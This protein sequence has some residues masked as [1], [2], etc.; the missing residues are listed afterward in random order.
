MLRRRV[1]IALV[2]L[3]WGLL[4]LVAVPATIRS[5][6]RRES[7]E[8]LN[9]AISG[10]EVHLV[11]HY[12][13][14]WY[15]A[16]ALLSALMFVAIVAARYGPSFVGRCRERFHKRGATAVPEFESRPLLAA[17][18]VAALSFGMLEAAVSYLRSNLLFEPGGEDTPAEALWM[19][20][21]D[22]VALAVLVVLLLLLLQRASGGRLRA[23]RLALPIV[24]ALG[25]AG[26]MLAFKVLLHPVAMALLSIGAGSAGSRLASLFTPEIRQHADRWLVRGAGVFLLLPLVP[27]TFRVIGS[28]MRVDGAAPARADGPNVI[29]LIW[30]TV[31]AANLSLHGYS[32]PTSPVLD[33]VATHGVAFDWAFATAPWSLPSHAGMMTGRLPHE[34]STGFRLPMDARYPTIGEVMQRAGYATAGFT[35]NLV[36][37]SAKFGIGRGLQHYDDQPPVSAVLVAARGQ[38]T[39]RLM[40]RVREAQG[41]Q[42]RMFRRRADHVNASFF[43]WIDGLPDRPF[44]AVLNH[45]DAHEPYAPPPPFNRT[46]SAPGERYWI[47]DATAPVPDSATLIQLRNAY[48][49]GIRYLDA[50]LEALLAGLRARGKLDRTILII[51]SDHGEEF[52]EHGNAVYGHMKSLYNGVLHVPM[53][54]VAPGLLP[55]GTRSDTPV[56]IRD[57]P[58]TIVDLTGVRDT[59]SF[60]GRSLAAALRDSVPSGEAFSVI[61]RH[62]Y[63]RPAWP[64]SGGDLYAAVEGHMK[65]IQSRKSSLLFDLD[66]DYMERRDISAEQPD[67]ARQL[68]AALD[69]VF[70]P[71]GKR[72]ARR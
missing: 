52:G 66:A 35:A 8:V 37:G 36:Y 23:G 41:T 42:Q 20:P 59:A 68:Y 26:V 58:A 2:A 32:R 21:L 64:S 30:D 24:L 19:A 47:H 43:R 11:Q 72:R 9:Q 54:I 44:L 50:Q 6:Y 38:L 45:F 1:L 12:L 16:A 28:S 3:G 63:G 33:S 17:T 60:P 57:I 70:G 15:R 69:S 22:A 56:S 29:V 25:V 39:R 49:G 27:A 67:I 7:L 4:A 62:P 34:L 18:G 5:A 48:D 51:T 71:L 31:R 14:L 53:V 13:G 65:L 40:E 61:E 46:F 10:R 55:A